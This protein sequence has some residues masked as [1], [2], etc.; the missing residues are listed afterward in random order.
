MLTCLKLSLR[1]KC[2]NTE[3]LLVRIFLYSDWIRTRKYSVFGHFSRSVS[4]KFR[5]PTIYNFVVA[6]FLKSSLLFNSFYCL[7]LFINKTWRLNNLNTRTAM[8]AKISRFVI[9]V[10][11]IIY[12]LLYSLHDCIFNLTIILS[13]EK[14]DS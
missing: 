6:I 5:I 11:E 2:P 9:C 12:L 7:L 10:E 13:Y 3:V 4:W 8:N 1:E 14:D